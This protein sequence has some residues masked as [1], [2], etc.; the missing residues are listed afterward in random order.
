MALLALLAV[1]PQSDPPTWSWLVLALLGACAVASWVAVVRLG[2]IERS[3][4]GLSRPEDLP[5]VGSRNQSG[6]EGLDLGRV[7]QL[8]T[9]IR[10]GSRRLEDALLRS[11]ANARPGQGIGEAAPTHSSELSERVTNRMLA[12]GYERVVVI[13]PREQFES[14]HR[15][16][17]DVLVEARR[18]GAPCKGKAIFR[19]GALIDVSM[20]S[21]Y[22]IFP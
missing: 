22:A 3:L 1:V 5:A 10:E 11:L 17:G 13:T 12:L 18:D 2:E 4:R 6:A 21:A 14:I 9:E 7:E 19:G 20:Q 16:G 15:D 8:L